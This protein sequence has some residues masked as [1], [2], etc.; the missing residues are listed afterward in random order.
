[1]LKLS[2]KYFLPFL[3]MGMVFCF[4]TQVSAQHICKEHNVWRENEAK[5]WETKRR[6]KEHKEKEYRYDVV[7]HRNYWEVDPAI[8]YIKGAIT[9][10]FKPQAADFSQIAFDLNVA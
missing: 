3:Y 5:T 7:Y 2:P 6:F 4:F 10:Y 1:M 8:H 9:T